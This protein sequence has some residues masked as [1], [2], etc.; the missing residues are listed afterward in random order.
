[1]APE[2]NGSN[3]QLAA[4]NVRENNRNFGILA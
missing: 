2:N 4:A 1:M 3:R